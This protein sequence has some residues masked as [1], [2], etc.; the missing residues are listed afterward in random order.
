MFSIKRPLLGTFNLP[1]TVQ[2]WNI[3]HIFL[4]NASMWKNRLLV[5]RIGKLLTEVKLTFKEI[6]KK[7]IV[8]FREKAG[9]YVNHMTSV[10]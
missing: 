3:C 7:S 6:E 5:N 8:L 2:G 10:S 1:G 4:T 9:S